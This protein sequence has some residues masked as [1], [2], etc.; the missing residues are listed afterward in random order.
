MLVEQQWF[1]F[2]NFLC[3]HQTT[4]L[5][6]LEGKEVLILKK[7]ANQAEPGKQLLAFILC[8]GGRCGTRYAQT[9]NNK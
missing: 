7:L 9:S 5:R 3:I 1:D 8:L 4:Q 6:G 2:V